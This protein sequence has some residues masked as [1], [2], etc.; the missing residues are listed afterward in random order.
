MMRII[1]NSF[2]LT[3]VMVPTLRIDKNQW[4]PWKPPLHRGSAASFIFSPERAISMNN[5]I[6]FYLQRLSNATFL[7][8]PMYDR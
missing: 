4:S 7:L 1:G 3:S 6:P 2:F 8:N 5:R